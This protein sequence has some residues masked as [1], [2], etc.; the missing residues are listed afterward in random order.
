MTVTGGIAA[1]VFNHAE[2]LSVTLYGAQG[3]ELA[4]GELVVGPNGQVLSYRAELP[5]DYV[6]PVRVVVTDG[7][8][9][10]LGFIDEYRQA[11]ALGQGMTA[12]QAERFAS[13]DFAPLSAIAWRAEGQMDMRVSVTPL[14]ELAARLLQAPADPTQALDGVTAEQVAAIAA[15]VADFAKTFTGDTQINDILGP[16]IA[17]NADNFGAGAAD[18]QAYG[19][20]L[21]GLA[22]LD[23]VSGALEQTL[24]LLTRGLERADA[25]ARLHRLELGAEARLGDQVEVGARHRHI[26][27]CV[28][29]APCSSRPRNMPAIIAIRL[30]NTM[31]KKLRI[32]WPRCP[33]GRVLYR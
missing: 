26:P 1:G 13:A 29:G 28:A 12:E 6:G 11:L 27:G 23:A 2:T 19:R 33:A 10:G 21:A 31:P 16:V 14:T 18:A 24:R 22:G 5:A 17:I 8:R 15:A 9:D 4:R 25:Q 30:P 3:Q 32:A 20:A 7:A